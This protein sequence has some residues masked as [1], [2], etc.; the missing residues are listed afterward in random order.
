M[1][2]DHAQA[3]IAA[4]DRR[5]DLLSEQRKK[6]DEAVDKLATDPADRSRELS[7]SKA[8]LA[9]Y[10]RYV[11]SESAVRN[12]ATRYAYDA[13]DDDKPSLRGHT[14]TIADEL[15]EIRTICHCGHKATMVVRRDMEGRPIIDETKVRAVAA[16]DAGVA[17]VTA[18]DA[19]LFVQTARERLGPFVTVGRDLWV[20]SSGA[21]VFA[22]E[23]RE[24][25]T[26]FG[27]GWQSGPWVEVDGL[28]FVAGHVAFIGVRV[29]TDHVVVDGVVL[30]V[31]RLQPEERSW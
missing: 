6:L 4:R 5:S 12:L 11:Q 29:E 1:P 26:V 28:Q 7:R 31:D 3:A 13:H 22:G 16:T 2:G 15:R 27:P 14:D 21:P 9:E 25:W 17:F 8:L 18:D 19:G 24:G 20:H 30:L 10:L 23:G